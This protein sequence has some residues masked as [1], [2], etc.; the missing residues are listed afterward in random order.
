MFM[1]EYQHNIDT[2]GRIIVPAK[3]RDDLGD[4]FVVTR[5][6]DKCLFAY[7]MN[8]WKILEEKLKKLPLTKKDARAFT[9]FFFSGAIECEVDK[10][11]RINIPQPLRNYAV[12]EKECV[13]IGVSNRIE[14]WASENW[15]DYFSDSEESFAEIA[16]NLLDFDI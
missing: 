11:G 6:L 5:G 14:F 13:V 16:E 12:L 15:E 9:R 8:E 7:P 2:K 4:R 3:F 1:G 10:Q